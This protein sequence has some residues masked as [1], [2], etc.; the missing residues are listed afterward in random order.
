MARA[1]GDRNRNEDEN[2]LLI[3]H[4]MH[5]INWGDDYKQLINKRMSIANE[6]NKALADKLE[7]LLKEKPAYRDSDRA[8]IVR[9]WSDAVGGVKGTRGVTLYDFLLEYLQEDGR[10]LTTES[11]GRVRRKLQKDNPQLRGERWEERHKEEQK[12]IKSLNT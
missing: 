6:I 5:V 12:I 2:I 3:W 7:A 11:V 1:W 9:L 10:F 8:L 4:I